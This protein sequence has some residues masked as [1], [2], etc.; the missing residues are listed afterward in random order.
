MAD[1]PKPQTAYELFSERTGRK[2][3]S[4]ME[5]WEALPEVDKAPYYEEAAQRQ[6]DEPQEE[7]AAAREVAAATTCP[8][9][10]EPE[11]A[12]DTAA[13]GQSAFQRF[14]KAR[15]GDASHAAMQDWEAMEQEEREPFYEAA[16]GEEAEVAVQE[17]AQPVGPAPKKPLPAYFL[18]VMDKRSEVMSQLASGDAAGVGRDDLDEV[19]KRLEDEDA[20]EAQEEAAQNVR[21]T[22]ALDEAVTMPAEQLASQIDEIEDSDAEA[23]EDD[24]PGGAPAEDRPE[25]PSPV[26]PEDTKT[27]SLFARATKLLAERWRELGAEE[28]NVYYERHAWAKVKYE[29]E[30]ARWKAA[31]GR[32]EAVDEALLDPLRFKADQLAVEQ[33]LMLDQRALLPVEVTLDAATEISALHANLDT[34]YRLRKDLWTTS[35]KVRKGFAVVAV[36]GISKLPPRASFASFP[37]GT[38]VTFRESIKLHGQ[39]VKV[40]STAV[41]F[42]FHCLGKVLEEKGIRV[43]SRDDVVELASHPRFLFLKHAFDDKLERCAETTLETLET[44]PPGEDDLFGPPPAA[45]PATKPTGAKRKA[46]G[47]APPAKKKKEEAKTAGTGSIR[48]FFG[49]MGL[50]R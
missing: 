8:P 39:A 32:Q 37:L 14:L 45:A 24:Q 46:A 3:V 7:T 11:A 1:S 42:L 18:F 50:A 31:G 28:R 6:E 20:V 47:K 19:V 26:K 30:L 23:K 17:E 41:R 34:Q 10:E 4:G 21:M 36:D 40:A 2:S 25:A 12:E 43:A 5:A 38:T 27:S 49:A 15:G 35:R 48:N 29:E 9:N 44:V 22:Q 33:W 16:K 13:P